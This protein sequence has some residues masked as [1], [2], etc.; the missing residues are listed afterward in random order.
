MSFS[1]ETKQEIAKLS[2]EKE[3]C[4]IAELNALTQ[5]L[6]ALSLLGGGR[7]Q[8][9]YAAESL[10]VARRL[11]V[12]LKSGLR[13]R[14]HTAVRREKRFGGR[15]V[16]TLA[17]S[18]EE[19]RHL[20]RRLSVLRQDENGEDVFQG[21]PRRIVRRICC[22]RS[23][24]RGMFLGC[25]TVISPEKGYHAEFLVEDEQRARFLMRVLSLCDIEASMSMRRQKAVVYIK[26]GEAVSRLLA[27]LG[28]ARAVLK[29]EEVRTVRSV[30]KQ[31]TRAINCDHANLGKQLS[32][33]QRQLEAISHISR[34]TGL[35]A[36]PDELQALARLR[37]SHQD[38]SLEQLGQLLKPTVSKS[39]V[40]HRMKR[41]MD[42]AAGLTVPVPTNTKQEEI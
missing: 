29:V 24:L 10:V 26:N 28:A 1:G 4:M 39:A 16:T 18:A 8:L 37:I 17:L 12:L 14:V 35:S 40:Q 23:F 21:V 3:C 41:L 13:Y 9:K 7:I 20:L 2:P 5:C 33:A 31:V 36:L 19:S 6:G 30:Q 38:A 42:I 27:T 25:G 32:A 34:M 22:R 11:L 15:L